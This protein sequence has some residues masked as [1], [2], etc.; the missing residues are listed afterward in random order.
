[1]ASLHRTMPAWTPEQQTT[2]Y[3]GQPQQP[4][5]QPQPMQYG[6]QPQSGMGM[7]YYG[8]QPH[9][10]QPHMA[11]APA[12]QMV[13]GQPLGPPP[14]QPV[15][16]YQAPPDMAAGWR[17]DFLDF[18]EDQP[19]CII[20]L[21]CPSCQVAYQKAAVEKLGE[22]SRGQCSVWKDFLPIFIIDLLAS[23]LTYFYLPIGSAICACNLRA[24]M[25]SIFQLDGSVFSD[26]LL[27]FCCLSCTVTQQHRELVLRNAPPEGF[28]MN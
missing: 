2:N 17:A 22:P 15:S 28:L 26:S 11:I 20:S 12:P 4:M 9:P 13:I 16:A 3:Y 18:C 7:T 19:I 6:Q 24:E 5:Q 10:Q 23:G 25:R 1:M 8:Q 21:F 14:I 27:A